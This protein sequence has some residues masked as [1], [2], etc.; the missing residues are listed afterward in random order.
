[1]RHPLGPGT[2]YVIHT[3]IRAGKEVPSPS[4]EFTKTWKVLE[5]RV[6]FKTVRNR[7][8]KR[9]LYRYT[10]NVVHKIYGRDSQARLKCVNGFFLDVYE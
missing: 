10:T 6:P 2:F 7:E 8:D 5:S 3:Q 9:I 4:G 1:M